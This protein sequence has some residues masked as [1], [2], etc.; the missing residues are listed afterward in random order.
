MLR[1]AA[2]N[3]AKLLVG[4]N[5]FMYG[6]PHSFTYIADFGRLLAALGTRNEALGQVWFAPTNP[7]LTQAEFSG[8]IAAEL[9]RPVKTRLAGAWM[10]RLLGLFNREMAE[11][12]EMM[13]EW[14]NPYV[15]DSSKASAALGLQPTPMRQAIRETI[16]WCQGVTA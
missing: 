1:P 9:G 14:T 3:G 13:F 16:A 5:L 6:L 7:P 15:I 2:E 10:M 12:V 11:T 4:D 8:L